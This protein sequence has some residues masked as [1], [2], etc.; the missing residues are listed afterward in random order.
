MELSHKMRARAGDAGRLI[1][2]LISASGLYFLLKL[3][4]QKAV[5]ESVL[6]GSTVAT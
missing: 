1:L 6:Y 4:V 2:L 3:L 5:L